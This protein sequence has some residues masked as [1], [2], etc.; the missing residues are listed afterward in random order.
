MVFEVKHLVFEGEI[1]DATGAQLSLRKESVLGE[2]EQRTRVIGKSG[3]FQF[4]VQPGKYEL[5]FPF[6]SG[7]PQRCSIT[8]FSQ[9]ITRLEF[10]DGWEDDVV[11]RKVEVDED[12][13]LNVYSVTSGATYERLVQ[14]M[15]LSVAQH[16]RG[17]NR[18]KFWLLD[19]FISPQFRS[20][21]HALSQKLKFEYEFISYRW[22]EWL[23][24][25]MK[26]NEVKAYKILFLDV[27]F[28]ANVR[29]VVFVD[30]DQVARVD[31]TELAKIDLEG[32][33]Y[34]F[35]PFCGDKAEMA[36]Y[37]FWERPGS[38]WHKRLKGNP[39]FIRYSL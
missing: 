24:R 1:K 23:V 31:L 39:Y 28:P 35:V 16:K 10:P 19:P 14:I 22:P 33:V 25:Q 15:A 3:Y 2:K 30:S 17:N 32:H 9:P 21:M 8:R 34:G 38:Y 27:I 4:K 18:L 11:E 5:S 6:A 37:R 7:N 26:I 29:R 20:N 12:D 36:E 13:V